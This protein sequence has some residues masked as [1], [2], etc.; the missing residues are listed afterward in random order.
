[1]DTFLSG[2]VT[3]AGVCEHEDELSR[4]ITAGSF[5]VSRLNISLSRRTLHHKVGTAC[6]CDDS[7]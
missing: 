7:S 3:V 4:F 1:M 5:F 6:D 2:L